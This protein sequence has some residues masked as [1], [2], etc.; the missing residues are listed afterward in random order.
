MSFSFVAAGNREE[1]LGSLEALVMNDDLGMDIRD[2][3]VSCISN[4]ADPGP[5]Q[6]YNI[7]AYG[8]SGQ[9]SLVT[10]NVS[11]TVEPVP[12]A[13]EVPAEATVPDPA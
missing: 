13:Q 9:R 5:S 7:S 3:L 12:V 2:N 11:V 10:M 1:V 6:R 4:G 8:H